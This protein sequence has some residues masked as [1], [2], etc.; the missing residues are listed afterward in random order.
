MTIDDFFFK[1]AN[2]LTIFRKNFKRERKCEINIEEYNNFIDNCLFFILNYVF[3]LI[4]DESFNNYK[5]IDYFTI[6]KNLVQ[7]ENDQKI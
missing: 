5:E 6:V 4:F 3:K 7:K 2:N 1:I